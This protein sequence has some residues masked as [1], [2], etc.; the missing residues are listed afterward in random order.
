[1]RRLTAKTHRW[2]RTRKNTRPSETTQTD[3]RV[4]VTATI[5][6]TKK[7]ARGDVCLEQIYM[8]EIKWM[9]Y[10]WKHITAEMRRVGHKRI[11]VH[12]HQGREK[13]AYCNNVGGF[14][15]RVVR[16]CG[17]SEH[18]ELF[19]EVW[20][21]YRLS[22]LPLSSL[23]QMMWFV[24]LFTH[25]HNSDYIRCVVKRRRLSDICGHI[26]RRK[27]PHTRTRHSTTHSACKCVCTRAQINILPPSI[28]SNPKPISTDDLP[29]K[30]THRHANSNAQSEHDT[31]PIHCARAENTRVVLGSFILG[32]IRL[33]TLHGFCLWWK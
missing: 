14:G 24:L 4:F 25:T 21:L 13:T 18:I 26:A 8:F 31:M 15:R 29:E 16:T 32:G 11:N 7:S 10:R 2:I 28:A 20:P 9:L 3:R 12:P 19:C 1:M 22:L 33:R 17:I 30:A 23:P 5:A 27:Q 6:D